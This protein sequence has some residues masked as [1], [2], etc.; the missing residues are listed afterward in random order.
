ME[1]VN[2]MGK[3]KSQIGTAIVNH[4]APP[5]CPVGRTMT[6]T[7]N[8]CSRCAEAKEQARENLSAAVNPACRD[9]I[10]VYRRCK[11]VNC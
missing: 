10:S 1:L 5:P 6:A 4:H 2:V 3:K 9:H 11:K 8:G 7:T